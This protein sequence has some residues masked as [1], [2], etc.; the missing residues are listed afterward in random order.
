MIIKLTHP[1]LKKC[2]D[3]DGL[4]KNCSKFNSFAYKLEKQAI[5]KAT[6]GDGEIDE[7]VRNKYKGDGFE[8]FIEAFIRVFGADMLI[9][10]DPESYKIVDISDYGVDAEGIG[11][12][13]KVHTI[14]I[15][16]RQANCILTANDSHLSNFT[17][18]SYKSKSSGGFGVD[19]NDK[20]KIRRKRIKDTCNMTIIH[21]GKE[22]HYDVKENMLRD[23]REINRKD[24]TRRVDDNNIF[25]DC[26]RKSWVKAIK[27]KDKQNEEE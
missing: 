1:F 5:Q 2:I 21:C 23:V 18:L 20:C 12:N 3:P 14:Q 24:I 15:K 25:W 7:D 27:K 6:G 9:C 26:L 13:G 19:P 10:I 22:I 8:L 4:L 16:Y 11:L 17:Q